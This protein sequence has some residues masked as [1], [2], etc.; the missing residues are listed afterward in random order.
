MIRLL[1]DRLWICLFIDYS[2]LFYRGAGPDCKTSDIGNKVVHLRKQIARLDDQ[3]R[4]LD[5]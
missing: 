1:T 2:K 3:E 4:L 5:K